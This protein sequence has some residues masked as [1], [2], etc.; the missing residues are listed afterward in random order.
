[1]THWGRGYSKI[2]EIDRKK[3]E[4]EAKR[5]ELERARDL[6]KQEDLNLRKAKH[7]R[8]VAE[9]GERDE[10][11]RLD[12]EAEE[13]E[14]V[15]STADSLRK[16]LHA[17]DDDD[18]REELEKLSNEE[19][20]RELE[21]EAL[22]FEREQNDLEEENLD[23][24]DGA[25]DL[26]GQKVVAK[27]LEEQ[28][29]ELQE[30]LKGMPDDSE[31]L[32]EQLEQLQEY[33]EQNEV[34][35]EDLDRDAKRDADKN[36]KHKKWKEGLRPGRMQKIAKQMDER[37]EVLRNRV[38]EK[39][40]DKADEAMS[41]VEK[42]AKKLM[43]KH[44]EKEAK[45]GDEDINGAA[46]GAYEDDQL[47]NMASE[48][49]QR[50]K[51]LK[52]ELLQADDEEGY[53][54]A[55]ALEEYSLQ[56]QKQV[57]SLEQSAKDQ[58][59]KRSAQEQKDHDSA[60]DYF[61][62]ELINIEAEAV[63]IE[64]GFERRRLRR[65]A[66]VMSKAAN[67]LDANPNVKNLKHGKRVMSD[68]KNV[69]DTEWQLLKSAKDTKDSS[70][71]HHL[72]QNLAEKANEFRRDSHKLV[73]EA[74]AN[75]FDSLDAKSSAEKASRQLYRDAKGM[76]KVAQDLENSNLRRDISGAG[77]N[78][79]LASAKVRDKKEFQAIRP[80]WEKVHQDVGELDSAIGEN[81]WKKEMDVSKK[82]V[83]DIQALEQGAL[84]LEQELQ[85]PTIPLSPE[86]RRQ[87][88]TAIKDMRGHASVLR[89][90]VKGTTADVSDK[91]RRQVKR[92]KH[93]E[94][95]VLEVQGNTLKKLTPLLKGRP[96]PRV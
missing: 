44:E 87:Y 63:R 15:E 57:A 35:L 5:A 64:Q 66:V 11:A 7:S 31:K 65:E 9:Q 54:Q 71:Q 83:E 60:I 33:G 89:K 91:A 42:W 1:M 4:L 92:L 70:K 55:K 76:K 30:N 75:H 24:D 50:E 49:K 8:V 40:L 88:I 77:H 48:V 46:P 37:A 85:K 10:K 32:P 81:N 95:E 39:K 25:D 26:E 61:Q 6:K 78:V 62:N 67:E 84:E 14:H 19:L 86:T 29:K 3:E 45:T 80:K 12:T 69:L 53:R 17:S 58:K 23:P 47:K 2:Q 22:D 72:S 16:K 13:K 43:K 52:T 51:R 93:E 68:V 94:E 21:Q 27:H 18:N 73:N 59:V 28:W 90:Y 82:T 56:V 36:G 74:E 41:K 20:E 96:P 38:H 34:M 79:D